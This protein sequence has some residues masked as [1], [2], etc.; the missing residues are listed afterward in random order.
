MHLHEELAKR[1]REATH[2]RDNPSEA[3]QAAA[4]ALANDELS[5]E[6]RCTR[7]AA[8][9]LALVAQ[10]LTRHIERREAT[11]GA[12]CCAHFK[13]AAV[14]QQER[15]H[16]QTIP[17]YGN[18]QGRYIITA[19]DGLIRVGFAF[20]QDLGDALVA[21]VD[22]K[23]QGRVTSKM[24]GIRLHSRIQQSHNQVQIAVSRRVDHHAC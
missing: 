3:A 11:V 20:Q 16:V 19:R 12:T 10:T 23:A 15:D 7:S 22:G 8:A 2:R 13:R 14:A 6:L 9:L 1:K 17:H 21:T 5:D 18:H 24:P 4:G